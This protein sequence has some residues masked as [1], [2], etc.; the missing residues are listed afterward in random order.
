MLFEISLEFFI[1]TPVATSKSFHEKSLE[2]V[3]S[4]VIYF[5]F[6]LGI[7]EKEYSLVPA[8]WA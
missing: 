7:F 2:T 5:S 4:E 6:F 1:F 3:E 8:S